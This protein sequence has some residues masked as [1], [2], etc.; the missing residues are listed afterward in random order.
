VPN[1]VGKEQDTRDVDCKA[2]ETGKKERKKLSRE[3]YVTDF[4]YPLI[5]V[6]CSSTL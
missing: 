5:Y 6:K 2:K 3:R 4:F 1:R